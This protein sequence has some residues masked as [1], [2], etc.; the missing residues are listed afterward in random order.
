MKK[1]LS[2]ILVVLG[3]MVLLF[4]FSSCEETV[5]YDV[6]DLDGDRLW[7]HSEGVKYDVDLNH[8]V[9]LSTPDELYYT[10]S[11]TMDDGVQ[12][13]N[14]GFKTERIELLGVERL[15][16]FEVRTYHF[17]GYFEVQIVTWYGKVRRSYL[18]F[19]FEGKELWL[20][21]KPVVRAPLAFE[22]VAWEVTELPVSNEEKN[23]NVYAKYLILYNMNVYYGYNVSE[24]DT[25]ANFDYLYEVT[26][27]DES[28]WYGSDGNITVT[29]TYDWKPE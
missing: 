8:F 28:V 24:I 5:Y 23:N 10:D 13:A 6:Y 18:P 3:T 14:T 16:N 20:N 11:I 4:G 19:E 26:R 27:Y 17:K 7:C 22:N 15:G 1:L 29:V 21:E 25:I 12:T 9:L 2:S